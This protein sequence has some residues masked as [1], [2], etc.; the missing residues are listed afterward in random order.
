MVS[1]VFPFYGRKQSNAKK[2]SLLVSKYKSFPRQRFCPK[3]PVKRGNFVGF[4]DPQCT[5]MQTCCHVHSRASCCSFNFSSL[6]NNL[7]FFSSFSLHLCCDV[8]LANDQLL[9]FRQKHFPFSRSVSMFLLDSRF[10]ASYC[11]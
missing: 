6:R 10:Q 7:T 9:I 11:N 4:S 8:S 1:V 3:N 2:H 5:F